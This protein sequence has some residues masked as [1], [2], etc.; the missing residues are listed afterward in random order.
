[1]TTKAL[2]FIY[3]RPKTAFAIFFTIVTLFFSSAYAVVSTVVVVFESTQDQEE[4]LE[5]SGGNLS[6]ATLAWQSDVR[7][8]LKR[9]GLDP[10]EWLLLVL[11]IIETES[12]GNAERLPDIMQ[13]S[14][15]QGLPPNTISSPQESIRAGVKHLISVISLAESKGITDKKAILQAYNFGTAFLNHMVRNNKKTWD[16]DFAEQ[17]SINV[18]YPAVTGNDPSSH[19][20]RP[21]NTPWATQAGKP[22][23][24]TNG[25]N[26]HYPNIVY[27]YIQGAYLGGTFAG[28]F[29]GD[30]I[31]P[32]MGSYVVTSEFGPRIHPVFGYGR[33]HRG[34]DLVGMQNKQILAT[35]DGAVSA[36]GYDASS[37]G[38]WLTIDHGVKDGKQYFSRYLHLASR[39]SL[40]I[41]TP[42][43][44]GQVIGREGNTGASTGSHLHFEIAVQEPGTKFNYRSQVNPRKFINF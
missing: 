12:G 1:M 20:K 3:R 8:E 27:H 41:G 40:S 29:A 4:Q 30:F 19:R 21:Y 44:Q 38:H 23:M 33:L 43:K 2:S 24:I 16:I 22:Y 35:A 10:D 5:F 34:I 25:G 18:V 17:Y 36:I 31:V 37:A 11:G 9:Q 15:S 7:A 14:E 42:V 13:A 28:N 6:E 32:Y 39:P 26:F